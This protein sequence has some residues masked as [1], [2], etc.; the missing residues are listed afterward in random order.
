[1]TSL[2]SRA[3]VRSVLSHQFLQAMPHEACN[4]R[5]N[6]A[7]P[8]SCFPQNLLGRAFSRQRNLWALALSKALRGIRGF[9][10]KIA[11]FV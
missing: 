5:F 2:R 9:L 11:V 4:M 3:T 6:L 8:A 1:M 7:C 10:I